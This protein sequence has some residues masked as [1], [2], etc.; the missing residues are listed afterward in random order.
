MVD[1][2]E[3]G[4]AGGCA[5]AGNP[6]LEMDLRRV[7]V[8]TARATVVLSTCEV[9]D[10]VRGQQAILMCGHSGARHTALSCSGPA[11]RA[12]PPGSSSALRR[13]FQLRQSGGD[14]AAA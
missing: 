8:I 1:S 4:T 14:C 9:A 7:S 6:H 11:S 13:L 2:K 5:T 10:Q 3:C 12:R